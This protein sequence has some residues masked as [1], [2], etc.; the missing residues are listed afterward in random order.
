MSLMSFVRQPHVD[1]YYA[2]T[3]NDHSRY[4]TLTEDLTVDV[5]VVGGGLAG[6]STALNLAEKGYKVALV[7][8][9]RI[10]WGASGRNGGQMI[11]GF[12]CGMDTF[13]NFMS[14]DEVKQVWQMG[15][16]SLD[17]IQRRVKDHQI[18][19]DL[20]TGYF[21]AANKPRH[22]KEL[23]AWQTE[24]IQR[25]GHN[26]FSL[27]DQTDLSKYVDTAA[28][29]GGM[30]DPDSGH[31]H[32]LNYNLGLARAAKSAGAMIF[33][34]T[35]ATDIHMSQQAGQKNVVMTPTGEIRAEWLVLACNA[36]IGT[37]SPALDRKIMPV[38]TYVI[39]TEPMEKAR[40]DALM[41]AR[42]AVCDSRF[43]LDYFRTTKDNR[44]LWGGKVSYSKLPPADLPNAMRADMLKIFPQ[45]ADLNIEHA[46]GG[47]CD[48]TM[49]RAPHF[50]RLS[51]TT[52]FAQGFSGHGVNVTGLAGELIANAIAGQA[53]K[54]DLFD[55]VKHR[56]FPGGSLFRT[57]ALVM[58]MLYYRLKDYL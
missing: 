12:A 33:E 8:A 37:L 9:S 21:H 55:K 7:E 5:C 36:Y 13:A 4:P 40:C 26:R 3:A 49:S 28:Y 44:M 6:V 20:K 23:E 35:P 50:G 19:C 10:G 38:G 17:I 39:T 41:P 14:E 54:F 45:L 22:L 43:V 18:D 15:M 56:D 1:S 53:E 16:Y 57:P 46:W 42:A 11:Y 34:E 29:L 51:P 47:F 30:F 31:L 52:Y 27:V 24:A 25:F 32:P 58:A 2:A 48:I